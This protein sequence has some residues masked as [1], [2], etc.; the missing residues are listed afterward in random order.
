MGASLSFLML[1]RAAVANGMWKN[2]EKLRP[3]VGPTWIGAEL[4]SGGSTCVPPK[5]APSGTS[6]LG[7]SSPSQCISRTRSCRPSA[8]V[9]SGFAVR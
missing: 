1:M 3:S 5:K 7:A 6:T 8:F 4:N 2:D 9:S